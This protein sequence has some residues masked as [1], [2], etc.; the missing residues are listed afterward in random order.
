MSDF[1]VNEHAVRQLAAL[2]E[3]MKLSEIEYETGDAKIRVARSLAPVASVAAPAP[4]AAGP[5]AGPSPAEEA[6]P[7]A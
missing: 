7:A 3:E 5:V 4:P 1:E 6:V 2:L